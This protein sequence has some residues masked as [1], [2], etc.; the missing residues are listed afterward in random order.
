MDYPLIFWLYED[1]DRLFHRSFL[2]DHA[3]FSLEPSLIQKNNLAPSSGS[4]SSQGSQLPEKLGNEAKEGLLD[5]FK[6]RQA[7]SLFENLKGETITSEVKFPGSV[8]LENC[9]DTKLILVNKVSSITLVN[10]SNVILS[11]VSVISTCELIRC[12]DCQITCSMS[13]ATYTLDDSHKIKITFPRSAQ[14]QE[15]SLF[16]STRSS[17]VQLHAANS[18]TPG[19]GASL[20]SHDDI[21][22]VINDKIAEGG[23]K[24]LQFQTK[25]ADGKFSTTELKREGSQGYVVSLGS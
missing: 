5:A 6:S 12:N 15:A 2:A 25:F 11:F 14:G 3:L 9:S 16:V 19:A 1:D 4:D 21:T 13:C 10:C 17:N 8:H 18:I 7:K 20:Q 23:S 24:H 22:T